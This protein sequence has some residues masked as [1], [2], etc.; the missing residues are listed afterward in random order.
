MLSSAIRKLEQ[1]DFLSATKSPYDVQMH[2]YGLSRISM[3][4]L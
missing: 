1:E 3:L 4:I 2:L